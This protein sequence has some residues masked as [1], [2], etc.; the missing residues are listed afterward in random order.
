MV[1][2]FLSFLI[3]LIGSAMAANSAQWRPQSIY[4]LLT[5]RFA[6]TDNSTTASCDV[7]TR[8]SFAVKQ[9]SVNKACNLL[10]FQE[11][12]G[13]SWQGIINQVDPEFRLHRGSKC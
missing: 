12:C 1:T 2:L 9:I 3:G 7:I 5:D 13:G 8:V 6:R 4:F 11:Y 10:Y